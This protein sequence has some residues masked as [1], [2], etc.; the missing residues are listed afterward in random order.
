MPRLLVALEG[1]QLLCEEGRVLIELVVQRRLDGLDELVLLEGV[2]DGHCL[3]RVQRRLVIGARQG[4][5]I[6]VASVWVRRVERGRLSGDLEL[7]RV[8]DDLLVRDVVALG[9]LAGR[10]PL[11][12]DRGH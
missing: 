7:V 10:A 6:H 5:A 9:L 11:N 2:N 12:V 3:G 4:A 1:D 8:L